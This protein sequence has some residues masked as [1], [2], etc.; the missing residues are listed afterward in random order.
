MELGQ[1]A[2][3]ITGCHSSTQV[4][5]HVRFVKKQQCGKR[6]HRAVGIFFVCY[7]YSALLQNRFST[8]RACTRLWQNIA[9]TWC[10]CSPITVAYETEV[11]FA[12]FKYLFK[13]KT[14][15]FNPSSALLK[16]LGLTVKLECCG[17]SRH[18]LHGLSSVLDG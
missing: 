18:E 7:S 17:V 14:Q 2:P 5:R 9:R 4:E 8:D 10:N 11:F 6:E 16:L 15:H 13:I 1:L 12:F 3:A